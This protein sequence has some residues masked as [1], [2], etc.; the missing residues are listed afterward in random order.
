M[1]P[2]KRQMRRIQLAIL[3]MLMLNAVLLG[4][5]NINKWYQHK[6]DYDDFIWYM[7]EMN[8]ESDPDT[9]DSSYTLERP[10]YPGQVRELSQIVPGQTYVAVNK[11][12]GNSEIVAVTAPYQDEKG[13]W[14]FDYHYS[15]DESYVTTAS[16]ADRSVVPYEEGG[17]NPSNYL[18]F[19][20]N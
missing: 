8:Y 9:D 14:W 11:D 10:S 2:Y 4:A 3:F 17:W 15:Y 5:L 1:F 20:N 18:L 12:D 13:R 16:L 7:S 19:S 6:L